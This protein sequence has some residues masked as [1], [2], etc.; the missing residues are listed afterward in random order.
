[1]AKHCVVVADRAVRVPANRLRGTLMAVPVAHST[2]GS[3][4]EVCE[5][6]DETERLHDDAIF[7]MTN[8]WTVAGPSCEN[9]W[10]CDDVGSNDVAGKLRASLARFPSCQ[11]ASGKQAASTQ[12]HP[13]LVPENTTT[14]CLI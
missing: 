6:G 5:S 13:G 2:R 4:A 1:M 3:R 8:G 14:P 9:L 11:S 12:A 10:E 7:T